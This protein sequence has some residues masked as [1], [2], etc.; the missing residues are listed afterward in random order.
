MQ[1]PIIAVN[2][3][4][5]C[6]LM[7]VHPQDTFLNKLDQLRKSTVQDNQLTRLSHYINTGFPS[8]KKNLL[9]DL[10][11]F[12]NHR[13]ALSIESGLITCGNRII[14]PKEMRPKMLQYIQEGHQGKERCLL[15]ARNTVFWP[16]MTYDVQELIE[17]CIICQEHGKSQPIIGTTQ[18]LPPFPWHTLATDI[19]YWKRMDFLIVAD[20]FSKVLP[21]EEISQFYICSHLCRASHHCNRIRFTP[22]HQKWQWTMLQFQG[23]SATSE[24]LHHTPHQQPSPYKI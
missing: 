15:Q 10:H 1:L 16:K 24:M 23:I 14:V 2:M 8:D 13:E 22:H 11:E 19:F 4:T 3:I 20:V 12:W 17:R 6:I 9:T 18:E 7:S 5:T 21:S